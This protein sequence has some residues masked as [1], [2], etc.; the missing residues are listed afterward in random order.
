MKEALPLVLEVSGLRTC[1]QTR[2][3]VVRA[4]DGVSFSLARGERLAI[5]GESGSGKSVTALSIMRLMRPP[6][7]IESGEILVN[8][9]SVLRMTD[10][11]LQAMRGSEVAMILQDP[12]SSLNPVHTVGKQIVETIQLHQDVSKSAARRMAAELLRAVQIPHSEARL[13]DYPH[14]FSGGMRQRVMIAM[15]L[16]NNPALLIADE[17]TTALDVTTQAQILELLDELCAAHGTAVLLITHDLGMVAGFCDRTIVMYGGR[18]MESAATWA[19]F[20]SPLHPY[21]IGLLD[22][23]PPAEEDV[24]ELTP[25][26]GEPADP[27]RLPPGCVFQ[28]R[29]RFKGQRSEEELP[30]LREVEPGHFAAC[31]YVEEIRAAVEAAR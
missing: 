8:G 17:P 2:R 31:H 24:D 29:C 21:T 30:E 7:R 13:D 10:R 11:E 5:V 15:A 27:R 23:I 28:S 26:P 14:Q 9:R 4:V 3:G 18:I 22:S 12:M 1:F 19:L 25:I 6:G 20:R 16:A